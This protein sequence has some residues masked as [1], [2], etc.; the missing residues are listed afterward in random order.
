MVAK[1]THEKFIERCKEKLPHLSE[2]TVLTEYDSTHVKLKVRHCCGH[3]YFVSPNKF[4]SGRQCPSPSCE[5]GRIG[6]KSR[7]RVL[8]NPIIPTK[9]HEIFLAEVK[10][11]VGNEYSVLTRY[12]K[13]NVHVKMQHN[14]CGHEYDVW[15]VSFVS[16][17]HSC[18]ICSKR[19][20]FRSRVVLQIED[21]LQDRKIE[22]MTEVVFPEL[23]TQGRG[24]SLAFD[25][26]I[27]LADG[28]E[29]LL[30]YDGRQHENGWMGNPDDLDKQKRNDSKKND[31]A[32]KHGLNFIRVNYKAA[33]K[34][35]EVLE[36]IINRFE[37]STT[38]RGDGVLLKHMEKEMDGV[39]VVSRS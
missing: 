36:N 21:F 2:Y 35:E 34:I 19:N 15:P 5:G 18:P 9:T 33:R 29:F 25:F 16:N 24:A 37:R 12:V 8:K 14:S 30:E 4:L 28:T 11:L 3:E 10:S 27:T 39:C 32:I 17:G 6:E 7:A 23:K 31:F 13:N 20:L 1:L 38:I 22:F 26:A